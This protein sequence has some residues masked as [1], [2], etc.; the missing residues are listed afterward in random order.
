MQGIHPAGLLCI[1]IS[2]IIR[3]PPIKVH[4]LATDGLRLSGSI[5]ARISARINLLIKSKI[6]FTVYKHLHPLSLSLKPPDFICR[7]DN[8]IILICS[9]FVGDTFHVAG[10]VSAKKKHLLSGQVAKIVKYTPA[11][12]KTPNLQTS[13]RLFASQ[14]NSESCHISLF[15]SA[16][17]SFLFSDLLTP[18]TPPPLATD[19]HSAPPDVTGLSER[20]LH[21]AERPQVASVRGVSRGYNHQTSVMETADGEFPANTQ[22]H[23]HLPFFSFSPAVCPS[24]V[25]LVSRPVGLAQA[26]E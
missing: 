21:H 7:N 20:S 10:I 26:A 24:V 6:L 2:P 23:S 19:N 1:T 12:L 15:A 8:Y 13:K 16:R 11:E 18:N 22:T 14:S 17:R 4:V 9:Y 25:S 3:P 5:I